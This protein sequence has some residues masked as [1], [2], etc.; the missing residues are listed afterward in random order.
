M[1][2]VAVFPATKEVKLVERQAP[3]ISSPTEVK[4]RMLEVGVCGTDKEICQFDYGTPPAGSEYLVIGHESLAEVV[5]TGAEVLR[6]RTGDL[7]VTS[8]RRPCSHANCTAC[9]MGRQDF[10]FT[11][12]YTE[13]GIKEQHGY[14]TEFVVDDEKY[15]NVVP[16]SLR[17]IGVLVEPLTIAE[18]ALTQ[19]WQVQQRL[20]WAC[21]PLENLQMETPAGESATGARQSQTDANPGRCHSAVVLGAGPVGLLGAMA[22]VAAGFSTH[23]YSREAEGSEKAKIVHSFGANYVS[24][25][26]QTVAQLAEEVG[27]IDLVYEAVGASALAF[28]MIKVLGTNGVFVFT[29]VPGRKAPTP[30]DTDFLMRNLVLRNQVVFGTVNAGRDAFEAAIRDLAIFAKRFPRAVESLITARVPIEEHR[31]L[32]LGRAGGIKN[33]IK[34]G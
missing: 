32:L 25:E 10:C 24:A 34:L 23:V 12:D 13:R 15:M 30:V 5:E 22:L 8:V 28:E 19:V 16:A 3:R 27:G 18:K 17:E 4:L 6:V 21:P 20:P 1:K 11:G 2:A 9:R 33:V 31:D 26:T 29:G 7:V 14:M